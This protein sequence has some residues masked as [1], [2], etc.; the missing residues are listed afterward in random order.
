MDFRFWILLR[1]EKN[2]KTSLTTASRLHSQGFLLHLGRL[3]FYLLLSGVDDH[4]VGIL[5]WPFS[6]SGQGFPKREEQVAAAIIF[7]PVTGQQSC[8]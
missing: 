5:S 7:H 6:A 8:A 4:Q 1:S 3:W 2:N